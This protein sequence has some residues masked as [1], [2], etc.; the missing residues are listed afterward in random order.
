MREE[1][2][3][4][5]AFRDVEAA[6]AISGADRR[7]HHVALAREPEG[8]V[9]EFDQRKEAARFGVKRD[10]VV[11]NCQSKGALADGVDHIGNGRELE[12]QAPD[13]FLQLRRRGFGFSRSRAYEKQRDQQQ[14]S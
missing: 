14:G 13:L 11:H 10:A 5:P 3:K 8:G 4:Q 9:A 6:A 1:G 2:S 7:N 12:R